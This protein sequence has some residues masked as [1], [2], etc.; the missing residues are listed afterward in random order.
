MI[1][2]LSETLQAILD[3]PELSEEGPFRELVE[4]QV[5]FERPSEQF[6]PSQ[7]TVNLFLFDIREN[8]ELREKEP[9][10]ERLNGQA[11]IRRPPM[12]VD[13]SYL[14]TAWAVGGTGPERVLEEHEL[15][16]QA[17]QVLAR[18]PTVPGKFLQGSLK[19]QG[20]PLPLHV[21]G[22]NKGEMRDPADFW[23]ALGNKLRPSLIV[24]VTLELQTSA[25]ETA[26]LVSKRRLRLGL[27]EDPAETGLAEKT[28]EEV[29]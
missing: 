18:Y 6:N 23:T 26:P 11:L 10:V 19:E 28:V 15:L 27:R 24:T 8:V 12:R 25:P 16:G 22:T 5:A 21:G 9:V 14:L 17:M 3:D 4:A 2:D 7:T 20:R 13:C 1:R 29:P